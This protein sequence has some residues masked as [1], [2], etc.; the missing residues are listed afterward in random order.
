MIF[1]GHYF[2]IFQGIMVTTAIMGVLMVA[3]LSTF[4]HSWKNFQI[5][6]A[7]GYTASSVLGYMLAS[8]VLA[9][10]TTLVM[11]RTLINDVQPYFNILLF[12][13]IMML[14]V[15]S[16]IGFSIGHIFLHSFIPKLHKLHHCCVHSSYLTNFIFHPVDIIMEFGT[17]IMIMLFTNA[18]LIKDDFATL[19]SITIL[20]TWYALDHD[21]FIH[22]H[23]ARHHK[24]I[25][26]YYNAYLNLRGD[27]VQDNVR[28]LIR[29]KSKNT[30]K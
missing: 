14:L 2:G 1:T 23:H 11:T 24:V 7:N 18:I 8:Y 12:T 20:I 30:V 28:K 25:S 10:P 21:V 29:R 13:R 27:F 5:L 17:P 22:S 19:A 4:E 6:K 3:D 16:E 9:I 26:R 15:L